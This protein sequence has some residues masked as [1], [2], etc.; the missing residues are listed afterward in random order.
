MKRAASAIS[1]AILLLSSPAAGQAPGPATGSGEIS[2][3]VLD[4]C[5][6]AV[7]NAEVTILTTDDP[8]ATVRPAV[9]TNELG[10][11]RVT[12]IPAGRYIVRASHPVAPDDTRVPYGTAYYPASTKLMR[13]A[14]QVVVT[15]GGT[16]PGITINL[17]TVPQH[18]QN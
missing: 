7:A 1:L 18:G 9:T 3:R 6:E 5:Y 2:G 17:W 4:D 8:P 13:D 12:G 11:F 14:G 15:P 10:E 16:V